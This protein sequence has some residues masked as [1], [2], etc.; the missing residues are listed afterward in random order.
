MCES[1]DPRLWF[2]FCMRHSLEY[3]LCIIFPDVFHCISILAIST[4]GLTHY[5]HYYSISII[6]LGLFLSI[7]SIEK[8]ASLFTGLHNLQCTCANWPNWYS[9]FYKSVLVSYCT[10][11]VQAS[12]P[13]TFRVQLLHPKNILHPVQG[14]SEDSYPA[15]K[16]KP[17]HFVSSR[18]L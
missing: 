6:Y 17:A 2:W 13:Y 5:D 4:F 1:R 10:Y 8:Y 14:C 15:Q 12:V 7:L 11:L 3:F 16:I 18:D 9:I